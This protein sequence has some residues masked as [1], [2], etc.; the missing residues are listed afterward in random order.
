MDESQT[1]AGFL[2]LLSTQPSTGSD[3]QGQRFEQKALEYCGLPPPG[4]AQIGQLNALLS[5]L[6]QQG[7][8]SSQDQAQ[9]SVVHLGES[10]N[11]S[12]SMDETEWG[13]N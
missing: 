4:G 6:L 2:C 11:R 10:K 1:R 5:V 13:G 12:H 8:L 7:L 9:I 3:S